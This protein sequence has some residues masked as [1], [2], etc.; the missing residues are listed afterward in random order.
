MKITRVFSCVAVALTL[1]AMVSCSG[2]GQ[3]GDTPDST[4]TDST[5]K[6][7]PEK[8]VNAK[9]IGE[10]K[11]GICTVDDQEAMMQVLDMKPET[12][13][14]V[15]FGAT[16]CGP[17]KEFKPVFE[18]VA[19]RYADRAQFYAVDIDQCADLAAKLNIEAVPT[20]MVK[21]VDGSTA[22]Y[23]GTGDLLPVEKFEAIVQKAVD[24]ADK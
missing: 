11:D 13:I 5:E 23:V 2:S 15:D 14:F 21:Y 18:D 16:W 24:Q 8:A 12:P 3:K 22:T 6:F 7:D 20:L 9:S 10:Y 17:C 4:A 19:N 1:G